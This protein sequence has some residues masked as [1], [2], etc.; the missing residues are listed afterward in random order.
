MPG[1]HTAGMRKPPEKVQSSMELLRP[2]IG[3]GGYRRIVSFDDGLEVGQVLHIGLFHMPALA[4]MGV[5]LLLR[6]LQ[7]A[8]VVHQMR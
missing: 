4:D 6:L 7:C 1:P 2:L 5:Q 8:A 3:T